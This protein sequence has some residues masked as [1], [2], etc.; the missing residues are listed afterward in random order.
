MSLLDGILGQLSNNP[1]VD[2]L[3]ATVGLRPEQVE[4]A[5]LA[6]G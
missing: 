6:L 1:T 2:N 5:V 3:A 4:H